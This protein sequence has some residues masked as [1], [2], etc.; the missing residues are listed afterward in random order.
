MKLATYEGR[1]AR[2]RVPSGRILRKGEPAEVTEEDA[3]WAQ[4]E[5]REDLRVTIHEGEAPAAPADS[6]ED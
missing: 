6:E 4:A 2:L 3:R 5:G 1:Y